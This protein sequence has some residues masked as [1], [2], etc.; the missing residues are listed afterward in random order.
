M[1]SSH[2]LALAHLIG[3][4]VQYL[5]W[6]LGVP[7]V[8]RAATSDPRFRPPIRNSPAV[9]RHKMHATLDHDLEL[10]E[11][12]V[13]VDSVTSSSCCR[14]PLEK[15]ASSVSRTWMPVARRRRALPPRRTRKAKHR[16]RPVVRLHQA[17]TVSSTVAGGHSDLTL[18]IRH[19]GHEAERHAVARS[20]YG[21]AGCAAREGRIVAGVRQSAATGR[22]NPAPRRSRSRTSPAGC[23]RAGRN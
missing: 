23:R 5:P 13:E 14:Q 21:G 22:G 9:A 2:C 15:A 20:S 17:V 8:S 11:S 12:R 16:A 6:L 18:V 19:V 10:G 4:A 1:R 7:Q 3:V